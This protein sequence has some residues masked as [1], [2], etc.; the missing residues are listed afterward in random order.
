[1]EFTVD[2]DIDNRYKEAFY[3]I[4]SDGV[5]FDLVLYSAALDGLCSR[6][7]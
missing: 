5:V 2:L 1:M 3:D 4:E 7:G 6:E